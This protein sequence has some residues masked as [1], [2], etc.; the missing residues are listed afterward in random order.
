MVQQAFH[1]DAQR[2][3]GCRTCQLACADYH[4]LGQDHW[5]RKVYEYGDG[6]WTKEG[7]CWV[8]DS[9]TYHVS[10]ACN[11][12]DDP[13]C[14]AACPTGAMRKNEETGLVGVD[15]ERCIGCGYCAMACP[16]G[17]PTIDRG[18]GHSVKCNG[19]AERVAEGKLPICVQS[20]PLHALDFGEVSEMQNLGSRADIAPLPSMD[21]TK[22]NLFITS[23]QHAQPAT[24][25][26]RAPSPGSV[27]NPTEVA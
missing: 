23:T 8:T 25:P 12:C 2:C 20:C 18:K 24:M 11:H 17:N 6:T 3:T 10:V 19:C 14:V 26:D 21:Y 1:F 15:A 9:F 4:N 13:A 22:P 27:L 5:Y 16:Y 7:D